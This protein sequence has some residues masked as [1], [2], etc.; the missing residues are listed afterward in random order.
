[1]SRIVLLT[2]QERT[3]ARHAEV[4]RYTNVPWTEIITRLNPSCEGAPPLRDR[5]LRRWIRRMHAEDG[6]HT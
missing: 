5:I 1:M 4:L 3:F 2:N 6:R